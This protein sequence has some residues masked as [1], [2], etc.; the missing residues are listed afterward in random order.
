MYKLGKLRPKEGQEVIQTEVP[1]SFYSA[2]D[3]KL[4]V[5]E[6]GRKGRKNRIGGGR[7][8]VGRTLFSC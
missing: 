4:L 7:G 3:E 1:G 6:S 2:H 5:G 8:K